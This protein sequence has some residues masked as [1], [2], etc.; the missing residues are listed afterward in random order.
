MGKTQFQT[1][2]AVL[3][4]LLALLMLGALVHELTVP[5]RGSDIL[6]LLGLSILLGGMAGQ[7]WSKIRKGPAVTTMGKKPPVQVVAT[8][9]L[10]V[11]SLI[12]LGIVIYELVTPGDHRPVHVL[13]G[14]GQSVFWAAMAAFV[15]TGRRA[16]PPAS[17]VRPPPP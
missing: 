15:W 6:K 10:G 3:L 11:A 2:A 4:G 16:V 13:G 17:S 12:I 8:V 14:L 9:L 1:V 5:H 7:M